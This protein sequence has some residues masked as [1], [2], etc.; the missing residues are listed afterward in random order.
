MT[1]IAAVK[2]CLKN[3]AKFSG[4]AGRPEFWWFML[5]IILAQYFASFID[6][7]VLGV[8]FWTVTSDPSQS[9]TNFDGPLAQLTS[10][11]LLIPSFAVG[12]RRLHDRD[13]SGW[14]QLLLLVPILGWIPLIVMLAQKG[15]DEDNRFGPPILSVPSLDGAKNKGSPVA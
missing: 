9:L 11:A 10:L 15:Q 1:F 2:T 8:P 6:T 7:W 3:Y 5:F 12:S 13:R 4:R 14:W